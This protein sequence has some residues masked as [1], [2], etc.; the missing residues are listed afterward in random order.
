[1]PKKYI[2]YLIGFV[3][4]AAAGLYGYYKW[5]KA[6]EKVNLWTL[7]PDDAVFIA[8][9]NRNDRL[10]RQLKK[11]TIYED[12]L[13]LPFFVT[14]QENI[15]LLDSAATRRLTLQEFLNQKRILTSVHVTSKTDFDLVMYLPIST[16][17]EHRYVRNVIDNV[18]KS[19]LFATEDQDY[20]GYSITSVQNK[21]AENTF[22]F[23]TYRNNIV[24]SPTVALLHQVIRK[25]NRTNLE[26]P[27]QEY[28]KSNFF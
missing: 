15:A 8:E 13:H 25:I 16:V 9:T 23:F 19:K 26:T 4:L 24:L 7:V 20:Q 28:A 10:I 21:R 22:Y 17:A 14:L 18:S 11:T 1:M 27:V 3:L 6:Q 5:Q 12:L 2:A